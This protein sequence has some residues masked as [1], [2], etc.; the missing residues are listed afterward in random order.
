MK[1]VTIG[2][3]RKTEVMYIDDISFEKMSK[4]NVISVEDYLLTEKCQ[5]NEVHGIS[6]CCPIGPTGET[7]NKE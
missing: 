5:I 1:K 3:G 7:G 2:A 4:S 6:G